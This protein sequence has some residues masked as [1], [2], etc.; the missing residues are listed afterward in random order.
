MSLESGTRLTRCKVRTGNLKRKVCDDMQPEIET[1]KL[2]EEQ[3]ENLQIVLDTTNIQRKQAL[4]AAMRTL[5]ET[6][7]EWIAAADLYTDFL[8]LMQLLNTKHHAWTTLTIF[9]MVAPFFACQTPFLMFLKEK[10]YRDVNRRLKLRSMGWVMVAPVMLAYMFILDIIFVI[11]Q[12]ILFPIIVCL[13]VIT[14]G[15]LDLSCLNRALEMTYEFLFEMHKLE[16][17][18]FRRMRTISQLTF[19]SLIQLMLQIRMLYVFNQL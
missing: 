6:V 17:A 13:K 8:V 18:G 19:E 12:A 2:T 9:S 10:V 14:F 16:V 4:G 1:K 7:L 5:L 11:N 3:I 15:F